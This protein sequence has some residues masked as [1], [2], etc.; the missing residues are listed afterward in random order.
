LRDNRSLGI[1]AKFFTN[2]ISSLG[3]SVNVDKEQLLEVRYSNVTYREIDPAIMADNLK[4]HA[5]KTDNFYYKKENDYFVATKVVQSANF[6]VHAKLTRGLKVALEAKG[7]QP[8]I[9]G[10]VKI[11]Y[12]R[13]NLDE[14]ILTYTGQTKLTFA[15]HLEEIDF[16]PNSGKIGGMD[17]VKQAIILMDQGSAPV[18]NTG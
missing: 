8:V 5:L 16:D 11:D 13:E 9:Q 1:F 15:V 17:S 14:A 6:M 10:E 3:V 12:D 7:G 18:W 4:D 2:I